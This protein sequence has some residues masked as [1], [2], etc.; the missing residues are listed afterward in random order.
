MR[1]APSLVVACGG[2][3]GAAARWAI[4]DAVG[5]DGGFGWGLLG[6]NTAGSLL[7]GVAVFATATSGR[8]WLR[9]GLGV[10]FCGS[11]TTFSSFAVVA[12]ELGRNGNWAS[13]AAF[14]LLTVAAAVV[15][16]VAGGATARLVIRS[17]TS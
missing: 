4:I 5:Y 11:F 7:L 3:A 17:R 2:V 14:V 10:G 6:V 8:D 13:A 12:A 9:L 15:A 1:A 16:L